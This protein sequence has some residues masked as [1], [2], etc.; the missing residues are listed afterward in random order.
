MD[1]TVWM[2]L[3]CSTKKYSQILTGTVSCQMFVLN[4]VLMNLEDVAL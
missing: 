3:G 2:I 4:N 1:D